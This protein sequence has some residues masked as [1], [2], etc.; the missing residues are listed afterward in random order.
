MK[1]TLLNLSVLLASSFSICN[2][3]LPTTGLTAY[4]PVCGNSNDV[5][6][7]NYHLSNAGASLTSDKQ[8]RLNSAYQFNGGNALYLNNVLPLTADFTYSCWFYANGAQY[9]AIWINGNTAWNGYGI[10]I[11]DGSSGYGSNFS[12][13]CG[14]VGYIGSHPVSMQA[15]HH[16][17]LSHSGNIFSL[18]LDTVLVSSSSLSIINPAGEF[19]IG[20][21]H[22]AMDV[23]FEGKIDEVVV[24]NRALSMAEI[25]QLF[26]YSGSIQIMTQPTSQNINTSGQA[27]FTVAANGTTLSYQWQQ[28][29][30]T[31]FVNLFN[32]GVYSGVNTNQLT[33]S[34]VNSALNNTLYRCIVTSP[35][36]CGDTSQTAVLAV[37][38]GIDNIAGNTG[39]SIIPNP[40]NG[41][42][43]IRLA[44]N[45]SK[46]IHVELTNTLGQRV[47]CEKYKVRNGAVLVH[48]M[49]P[50]G[51]YYYHISSVTGNVQL[52]A[53]QLIIK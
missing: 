20:M 28:N 40:S 29:S 18:Y 11:S 34:N 19:N 5:S 12:A 42:F 10:E 51:L 44:D 45:A 14:N 16:A 38:T 15:W 23:G 50:A 27:I 47:H 4:Y 6:G 2:A 32:A 3:Q 35:Y 53:G 22:N 17:V 31:G 1:K 48:L 8:G 36:T 41:T 46:D 9:G 26:L 13:F 25:K 43:E 49:V 37:L 21:N 7:G 24:Y 30:G 33:V 39:S 52:S